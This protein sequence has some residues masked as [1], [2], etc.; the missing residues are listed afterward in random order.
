MSSED[1]HKPATKKDIADLQ[2]SLEYS[3]REILQDSLCKPKVYSPAKFS[4]L[5]GMPYSTV[6]DHCV[7][8]LI[9]AKQDR[10]GSPWLIPVREVERLKRKE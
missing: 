3:F 6:V 8:G 4:E 2:C 9:E 7:K 1:Q 10:P 5:T